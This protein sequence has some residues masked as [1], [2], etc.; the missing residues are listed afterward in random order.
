MSD[1]DLPAWIEVI[2]ERDAEGELADAYARYRSP[3]TGM[4]D[5]VLKVHSLHVQSMRDHAA[6]YRTL[7]HGP[8]ALS[9][10]EREMIGVVVSG[11]NRCLY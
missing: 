5:N 10:V 3:E 8:G 9:R 2:D 6:M 1:R 11:A 4:I 7:M